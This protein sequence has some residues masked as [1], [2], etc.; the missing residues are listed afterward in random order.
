MGLHSYGI[1]HR[2]RAT[3][4]GQLAYHVGKIIFML[5]KIDHLD[6]AG[7]GSGQPLINQIHG[8][9]GVDPLLL[10]DPTRHVTDWSEPQD[11]QRATVRTPAYSTACQAV[12]STSDR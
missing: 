1:D 9:D 11:Q 2:I 7:N 12:G 4:V 10:G 6:A 5:S 8:N 3:S